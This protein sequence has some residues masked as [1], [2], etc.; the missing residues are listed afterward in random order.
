MKK[1][2][3]IEHDIWLRDRLLKGYEWAPRTRDNVRL[4]RDVA[5]F[6]AVPMEDKRLDEV[7]I[8]SIPTVL[9]EHG[10]MLSR[11][12]KGAGRRQ[13]KRKAKAGN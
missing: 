8:R 9:W 2:M 11:P 7:I 10:Y 13:R 12:R 4:H 5:V 1:L 3:T 6:S